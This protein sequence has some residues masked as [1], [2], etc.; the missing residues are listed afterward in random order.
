MRGILIGAGPSL[1][2]NL[3]ELEDLTLRLNTVEMP[4]HIFCTDR[5]LIPTLKADISPDYVVTLEKEPLHVAHFK[6]I[7]IAKYS[8][9]LLGIASHKVTENVIEQMEKM[10]I[11][12]N[13]INTDTEMFEDTTN[14][15]LFTWMVMTKL[16][17]IKEVYMIGMDYAYSS[18]DTYT[19]VEGK[20]KVYN[21][22]LK[23]HVTSHIVFNNWKEG[24]LKGIRNFDGKTV[25]CTGDGTLFGDNIEWR[26][27]L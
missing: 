3:K 26:D 19:P 4:R 8:D 27:S 9:D 25:N 5:A 20:L 12:T 22:H 1:S 6:D 21:P 18:L 11:R 15:G 16:F 2:R 13:V 10:G 7:V 23:K 17:D 14:V 24:F